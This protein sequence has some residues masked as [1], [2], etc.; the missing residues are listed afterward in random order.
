MSSLFSVTRIILA[1]IA[2]LVGTV[3]QAQS[4]DAPHLERRGKATQ[5]IVDGKP[6]LVLGGELHNSSSSDLAYMAPIWPR[7]KTMNLNTVLAPVAWETIEPQEGRFDFSNVDGLLRGARAQNLRL[8]LLWFGAWKN[9]YSSYVPAWVKRDQTRFARAQTSDGR[10]TERLSPFSRTTRDADARAFGKLMRH[11]R[12]VDGAQHTVLMV[13]VENEVGVIPE[14]R[15][16]SAAAGAALAAAVPEPLLRYLAANRST[17]HPT[18]RT[19]WETAGARTAGTWREVFGDQSMTDS[20]FMSWAY[21]TF[22]EG[23]TAAGKAEYRLPMFTNAALIRPN[24]EPGQYNSGGPLPFAIDVYKAGA[25]SLD[26]LAPDIYFEDYASWASQYT[27]PDNPLFVPEARGGPVGAAN[28]L[29]SFGT[30]GAVGFS[31][32]GIDGEGVVLQGDASI[33]LSAAGEGD[34]AMTAL[35]GQLAP[36][37]PMILQKQVEGGLTTV[38][39]E[40]GAQRAGRGR[41]GDY[42]VNMTRAGG[43]KGDVDQTSR[44]AAMF[45]QTAPDEFLVVGSGDAQLSFTTD[46]PGLPIVGIESIDEQIFRDGQSV[47]GRRLN[48]DETG[49]GQSLRLFSKDSGDGKVYRL[50]LYRYR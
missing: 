9:T 14:S 46:R 5:L 22:I 25:P 1:G 19:A 30:L 3:A 7:L 20:L 50:R 48:G 24:Y 6:F 42:V 15:D 18:L 11:L 28:A 35:Y 27:R 26:F 49:Q 10:G 41:I 2:L 23:V 36:L 12:A 34:P 43:A 13:Q 4:T 21:A 16:H 38:L 31:P 47:T 29:Y 39:M 44:V 33:G 8:V 17:L 37:A 40:G 45:L 32:F